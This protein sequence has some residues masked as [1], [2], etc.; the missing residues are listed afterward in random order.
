[1][2][3]GREWPR[4]S[5]VTPSYNQG[6]F[7]EAT[8][9]S[10]LLQGSPN[11][12]YL[13][14]DGGSEDESAAV[15][16]KYES[17]LVY[18]VSQPDGGPEFA[19]NDG[20]ARATGE[21]VSFLPSDDFYEP[22]ALQKSA[23][24]LARH[25]DAPFVYGGCKIV[26]EADK[27]L[28]SENPEGPFD[29]DRLLREYYF[30]APTV[31]IRKSAMAK[32]GSMDTALRFISDWDLWLRLALLAPPVYA[33]HWI[34][35]ARTWGGSKTTPGTGNVNTAHVPYERAMVLR[36]LLANK[37]FPESM[38]AHI[39]E[40]I[41]YHYRDWMSQLA[42]RRSLWPRLKAYTSTTLWSPAFGLRAFYR[43]ARRIL[44]RRV[45]LALRSQKPS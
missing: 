14:L 20:W 39:H 26:D 31:L 2:P 19:I 34:A 8:I 33:A 42:E 35:N 30:M 37:R 25:P 36:R 4:I 3:D 5:V 22:A 28:W 43:D 40:M 44:G 7:L 15:I 1:M 11:L 10:V 38:S 41:E 32:S 9:R 12:E 27:L 6:R 13:I 23:L 21:L 24:A 18:W 45:R 17:F 29:M 16:R